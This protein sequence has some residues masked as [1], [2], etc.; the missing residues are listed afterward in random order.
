MSINRTEAEAA[1][2]TGRL[3]IYHPPGGPREVGRITRVSSSASYAFVVYDD[4]SGPKATRLIDL[5][6]AGPDG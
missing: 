3:V 6:W 1:A 4:G 2:E 5:T